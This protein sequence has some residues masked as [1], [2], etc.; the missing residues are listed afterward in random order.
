MPA[1][2]EGADPV[3]RGGG[4]LSVAGFKPRFYQHQ[5]GQRPRRAQLR[6]EGGQSL[7]LEGKPQLHAG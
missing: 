7:P 4:A 6:H 5:P 1:H 2:R 3:V